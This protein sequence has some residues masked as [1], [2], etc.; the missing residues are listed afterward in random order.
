MDEQRRSVRIPVFA[1][2]PSKL[3]APQRASHAY[4]EERLSEYGLES[5]TVGYPDPAMKNPLHEVRTLA[6]HCAGGIIMGYRQVVATRVTR[7]VLK[8]GEVAEVAEHGYTAPTPWNHLETGILFGLALP[9]FVLREEGVRGGIFDEGSG[10]V[11]IHEMPMPS[12][13]EPGSLT[14]PDDIKDSFEGALRR[15]QAS[16]WHHYY[17]D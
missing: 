5:R 8:D 6:R 13:N 17:Q 2:R 3:N 4:I 1:S 16:V 10:D 12:G 11:L 14:I 7:W 9:L 15:W